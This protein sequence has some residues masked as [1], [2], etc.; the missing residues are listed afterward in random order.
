[1]TSFMMG[2]NLSGDLSTLLAMVR[3]GRLR[4]EIGRRVPWDAAFEAADALINR[5]VRGKVVLDVG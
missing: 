5:T 3:D 2:W 4:V 1:L